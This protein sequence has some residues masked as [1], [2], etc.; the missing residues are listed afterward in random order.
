[1]FIPYW[2]NTVLKAD[3]IA[4]AAFFCCS[5]TYTYTSEGVGQLSVIVREDTVNPLIKYK[6][7]RI[8]MST[9]TEAIINS[10]FFLCIQVSVLVG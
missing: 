9:T 4:S 1:M 2:F 8:P 3:V 5:V 6:T 7:L 10:K